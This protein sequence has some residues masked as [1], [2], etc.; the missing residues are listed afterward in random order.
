MRH[1]YIISLLQTMNGDDKTDPDFRL[2]AVAVLLRL[3]QGQI[4]GDSAIIKIG[5]LGGKNG[6]KC[7]SDKLLS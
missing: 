6:M 3:S 2:I 7:S 5:L 4:I 1:L